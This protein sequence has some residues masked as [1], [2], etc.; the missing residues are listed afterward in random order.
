[1][2]GVGLRISG[3]DFQQIIGELRRGA[4]GR[5][6][7][8]MPPALGSTP[9]NALAVPRRLYSQSRRATLPGRMGR[10]GRTSACSTT[11]FSSMQTTG[12]FSDSGF[13]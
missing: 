6:L 12:S 3:D 5:D 8:E 2:D 1:M 11:G 4:V 13:S 10:G 9:Q 7:G